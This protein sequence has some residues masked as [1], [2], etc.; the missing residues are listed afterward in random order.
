MLFDGVFS[1]TNSYHGSRLMSDSES[2]W[3]V[4]SVLHYFGLV[5]SSIHGDL[6]EVNQII[7]IV[8]ADILP[9]ELCCSHVAVF[10][11]GTADK[12]AEV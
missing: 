7:I 9:V 2:L 8:C 12:M 5:I 4:T 6:L 11:V 3:A 10:T 1:C